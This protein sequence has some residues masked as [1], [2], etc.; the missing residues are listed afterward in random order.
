LVGDV[1]A[2]SAAARRRAAQIVDAASLRRA[3][4]LIAEIKTDIDVTDRLLEL[5]AYQA[6]RQDAFLSESA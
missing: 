4:A 6:L 1:A 3:E 5:P 2:Q